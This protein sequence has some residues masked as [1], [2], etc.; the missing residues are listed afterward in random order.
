MISCSDL[1]KHTPK[2]NPNHLQLEKALAGIK[3]VM[4]NINEDKRKTEGQV[5]LFEI[6]NYIEN[7]PPH[8]VS[9]H[10]SF[11]LQC[12]VLELGTAHTLPFH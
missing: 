9:S 8:L 5:V 3:E 2:G 4:T 1:L 10:R 6:F 7:C 11:I 12:D